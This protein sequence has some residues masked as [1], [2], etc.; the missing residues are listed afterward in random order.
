MHFPCGE[1]YALTIAGQKISVIRS[2]QD[3]A[4]WW[5]RPATF[6]FDPFVQNVMKASGLNH[7]AIKLTFRGDPRHLLSLPPIPYRFKYPRLRC[8]K[9]WR[10]PLPQYQESLSYQG[11]PPVW[12]WEHPLSRSYF[13][14][15]GNLHL[16]CHSIR[17]A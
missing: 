6:T 4:V 10:K 15:I 12:W 8:I 11:L 13:C 2:T 1:P 16:R 3:V 17:W 7:F 5:K 9:L 14:T